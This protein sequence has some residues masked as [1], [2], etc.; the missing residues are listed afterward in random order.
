MDTLYTIGYGGRTPSQVAALLKER[1]ISALVDVR[2]APRSRI[3]G[4]NKNT[5][6]RH[7]LSEGIVY[8][9][10]EAL[11]NANRNAGPDAPVQLVD[12]AAGLQALRELLSRQDLAIMCA[13]RD[14]R[15]CHRT[16]VAERLSGHN[17]VHI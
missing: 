15:G 11:G 2:A 10:I 3:P 17:I 4:F 12:E 1:G 5:L 8:H 13:C 16:Y 9:H 14:H 6:A 7:M